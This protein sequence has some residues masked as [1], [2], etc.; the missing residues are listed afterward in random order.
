MPQL[1]APKIPR[2][3]I[4]RTDQ[5]AKSVHRVF[6]LLETGVRA[7]AV[8]KGTTATV[9]RGAC[10]YDVKQA[11]NRRMTRAAVNRVSSLTFHTTALEERSVT[12]AIQ[13]KSLMKIEPDAPL[14]PRKLLYRMRTTQA[15]V[16]RARSA[17]LG[18][19]QK[20]THQWN[21]VDAAAPFIATGADV[22]GV[23]LVRSR[24]VTK[25]PAMTVQWVRSPRTG[26]R[27]HGARTLAKLQTPTKPSVHVVHLANS[28]TLTAAAAIVAQTRARLLEQVAIHT[29]IQ[30][31]LTR[32]TRANRAASGTSQIRIAPAAFDAPM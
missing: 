11:S 24:T 2:N 31:H 1:L 18:L 7:L 5:S 32:L 28:Q 15:T 21:V 4:L 20:V 12:S 9:L 13:A 16:T 27:V 26:D 3:L 10:V 17:Q 23:I 30:P 14:A 6:I 19:N 29:A 25:V 22:S 8:M